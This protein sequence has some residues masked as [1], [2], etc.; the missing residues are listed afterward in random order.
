MACVAVIHNALCVTVATKQLSLYKTIWSQ[1][2]ILS[3]SRESV[4]LL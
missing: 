4:A 3:G 2:T 1:L